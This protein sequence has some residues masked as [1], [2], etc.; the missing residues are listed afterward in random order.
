MHKKC[1]RAI[2]SLRKNDDIVI[3]T[4]PDKDSGV[5]LL[6]KSDYV[7]KMNEMPNDQSKFK[8]LGPVSSND[9]TVNIELRLPKRLLDL[10]KV[11]CYQSAPLLAGLNYQY[12]T[13][14]G[15]GSFKVTA[16]LFRS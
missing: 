2:N 5:V 16:I 6:N 10:F 14:L 7:D 8:E 4:K 13:R 3:I 1:F 12:F 11:T 15:L 9:S